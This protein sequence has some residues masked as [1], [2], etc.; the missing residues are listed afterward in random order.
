M[1]SLLVE[2]Y[3]GTSGWL[4]DWNLGG[5]LEWYARELSSSFYR[6]PSSSQVRS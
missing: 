5:S 2:L 4:Y 1:G 3:A 6:I